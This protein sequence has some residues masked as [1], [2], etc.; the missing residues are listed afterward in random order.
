VNE[1]VASHAPA[2]NALV[3]VESKTEHEVIELA[4]EYEELAEH[5]R[6][7]VLAEHVKEAEI[8]V[9]LDEKTK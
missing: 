6:E 9:Q 5:I 8:V 2:N 4:K 1:L 3:N 7:E